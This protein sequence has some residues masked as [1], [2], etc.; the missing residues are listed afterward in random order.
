MAAAGHTVTFIGR[1][2]PTGTALQAAASRGGVRLL[3]TKGWEASLSAE[4]CAAAFTTDV[5]RLATAD[6]IFLAT[7][8]HDNSTVVPHIAK[9]AKTGSPV[10]IVA[11]QNGVRIAEEIHNLLAKAPGGDRK[12][13][14]VCESVVNLN[15]VREISPTGRAIFHWTSPRMKK[16]PPSFQLPTGAAAAV[17][18]AMDAAGLMAK[19]IDD[20]TAATYGKLIVNVV[21]NAVNALSGLPYLQM[22]R[23][24]GYRAIIKALYQEIHAVYVAKHIEYDS[25][26]AAMYMKLLSLPGPILCLVTALLFDVKGKASMWSDLHYNRKTEVDYLNGLVV[27]M[28]KEAGV[29]TP[30]NARLLELVRA[31]EVAKQ[32]NPFLSPAAIAEG[33]PAAVLDVS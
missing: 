8:R 7:K 11:M 15:V 32:G 10:L 2:S 30:V 4:R 16:G 13:M 12:E 6:V 25:S 26:G 22:L 31:A 27:D 1:N 23:S 21:G 9:Y 17:A 24:R 28:G 14:T 33:L 20:I 18:E 29:P 3:A 19:P 5:A